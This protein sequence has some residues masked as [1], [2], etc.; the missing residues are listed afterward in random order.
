MKD[1]IQLEKGATIRLLVFST[2]FPNETAPHHGVF[3]EQ[4]LRQLIRS[5]EVDASVIAPVPWFPFESKLFG[6]YSQFAAVKRRE[7]R[8]GLNITHPRYAVIPKIGMSLAPVLMAMSALRSMRLVLKAHEEFDVIDAHYFYPDGVAAAILGKILNKPVVITARGTDVNLIPKY[9]LPRR[10]ILWAARHS[11]RIFTVS[12]ALRQQLISM[13]VC[14]KKIDT[15]RN[16]VDLETFSPAKDRNEIRRRLGFRRFTLLSVGH[17]IERKGHDR[18]IRALAELPDVD[19][20]IIGDGELR[21][22]LRALADELGV[23]DRVT[24]AGLLS[25]AE[26]VEYYNAADALVLASSREGM[27]NVLLE[28]IA[29]GNPVVATPYWGSP[30]IVADDVAGQ[31]TEDRSVPAIIAAIRK[32]RDNY[33]ERAATRHYAE[34]FGWEPT[35]EGQLRVFRRLA[36]AVA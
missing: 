11:H 8:H 17:L 29:C 33:P 26:L 6:R 22:E 9:A 14:E 25:H 12:E 3:V 1:Q 24:W 15:L 5:G 19:L 4:R 18:V 23:S 20:V 28:S 35:T 34:Q 30:E 16:G 21:E 36:Q 10:W 13:G 32:L 7:R 31:L 27:A 2:L